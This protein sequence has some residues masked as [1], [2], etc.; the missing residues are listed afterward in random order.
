MSKK[1]GSYYYAYNPSKIF[2]KHEVRYVGEIWDDPTYGNGGGEFIKTNMVVIAFM[3]K[4]VALQH[5]E[6][7]NEVESRG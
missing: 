2:F 3:S 4:K 6:Y 5:V 1:T 7:L